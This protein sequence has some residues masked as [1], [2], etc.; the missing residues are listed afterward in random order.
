MQGPS[1]WSFAPR[2]ERPPLR[3]LLEGLQCARDVLVADV[4]EVENLLDF[5]LG[6]GDDVLKENCMLV[7]VLV[8]LV[9]GDLKKCL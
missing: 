4:H 3:V 7:D 6:I 8:P 1:L 2:T 9:I 5:P